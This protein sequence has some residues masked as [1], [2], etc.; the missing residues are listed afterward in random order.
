VLL[1]ASATGYYGDR[2]A[3]PLDEQ[4]PPGRG[5][6]AELCV[7]WE[8]AA[9]RAR[10]AGMRVVCCRFGVVLAPSGGA[11]GKMLPV[12]RL[13][14]GGRLGDG[15]QY[16]PWIAID[17]VVAALDHLLRRDDLEGAVN[18][19]APEQV[20]NARFTA[21][22]GRVLGRATLLPVP[23]FVLRAVVGA[24]A[25][26]LLLASARVLPERLQGSG[27]VFRYPELE[28][29]LRHLISPRSAAATQS[30]A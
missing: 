30:A 28:E 16:V 25:D 26:E 22:L 20:T 10:E 19:V 8:H 14:L 1:S 24:A 13:G 23:R 11:L 18:L 6:L 9:R 27:F 2:G 21:T 5:F 15:R 4:A 3:T 29:A 7:E 17:D 12:F